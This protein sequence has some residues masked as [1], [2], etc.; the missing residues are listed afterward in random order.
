MT[1]SAIPFSPVKRRAFLGGLAG[2]AAAVGLAACG[3]GESN[4]DDDKKGDKGG[5][6]G[7]GADTRS[8][9][10]ENGTI[11]APAHPRR[12]I[13]TENWDALM[14]LDLGIVPVGIPDGVA[15]PAALPADIYQKLRRVKTIGV[16]G[17]LN[18]QAIGALKPDLII[19]QFYKDKT[20]PLKTIAPVAYYNWQDSGALW[21]EQLDKIADAVN[22]RDALTDAKSEYQRRLKEVKE[23]YAQQ[24]AK[25]TWAPLSGGQNGVFFLGSTLLTVMRDLGLRIGAKIAPDEAGFTQKSYEELEILDDCDVLLYPRLFDGKP[26]A[27]TQQLLD[28]K[29]WKGVPAVKAGHAFP[30]QHYTVASYRWGN[31]AVDEIEK[32][33]QKL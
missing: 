32:I 29:V 27:L 28:N 7:E 31:G 19:D 4:D 13:A 12:V 15:N 2:T 23:K 11:E 14:L 21:Y 25:T 30:I 9:K 20:A 16:S 17:S 24:I 5:K 26:P 1:R 10:T 6:G 22:R 8:V 3:V 33:L 18:A